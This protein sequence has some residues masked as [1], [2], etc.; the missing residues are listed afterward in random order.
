MKIFFWY[1]LVGIIIIIPHF[2][3]FYFFKSLLSIAFCF[4]NL[5]LLFH[6]TFLSIFII[7]ATPNKKNIY[8]ALIII[9]FIFLIIYFFVIKG[10]NGHNSPAFAIANLGLTIFCIKYYYRLFNNIPILDLNK[11]SSFWII[12]GVF[13]CMTIHIPM[14]GFVDHINQKISPDNINLFRSI[15]GFCYGI[16]H[17]FFIKAYLCSIRP[18]KLQFL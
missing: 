14:L 1:P 5:S 13:F 16:M 6:F 2:L 11:E 8:D 18:L 3:S 4:S 7:K 10:I 17:L 12:T 9:L 15:G